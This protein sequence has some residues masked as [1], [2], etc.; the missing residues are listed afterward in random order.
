MA[1]NLDGGAARN[2]QSAQTNE[3]W[4]AQAFINLFLPTG[5][6]GRRKIGSIPLR[7]NKPAEK[8]VIDYLQED[9]S[10]MGALL[11]KLEGDFQLA[12][13]ST[14]ALFDLGD[15]ASKQEAS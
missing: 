11:S 14:G 9:D 3:N 12:D 5:D 15:T 10:R 13:G 8:Q 7:A 6:G 1:F 2:N 4:K